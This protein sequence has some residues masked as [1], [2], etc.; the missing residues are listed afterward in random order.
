M[1]GDSVRSVFF[2]LSERASL[3]QLAGP[4]ELAGA[5]ADPSCSLRGLLLGWLGGWKAAGS[6]A[7]RKMGSQ[8]KPFSDEKW[9]PQKHYTAVFFRSPLLMG[10]QKTLRY[11]VF[12]E[13]IFRR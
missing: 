7:R 10:T 5:L 6:A 13:P 4:I 12:W 1:W 3:W 9:G 11:N 2:R 8:K